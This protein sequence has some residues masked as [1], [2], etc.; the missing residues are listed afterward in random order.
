MISTVLPTDEERTMLRDSLRGLLEQHWPAEHAASWADDSPRVR[1]LDR[2]LAEQGL[3]GLGRELSEGASR[4][5][6]VVAEELGR[7]S[8][9]S[10]LPAAMSAQ[11]ILSAE[12]GASSVLAQA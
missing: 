11:R 8:C 4:E 12:T 6:L 9:P 5:I 1:A 10:L 2:L 3:A 7:A